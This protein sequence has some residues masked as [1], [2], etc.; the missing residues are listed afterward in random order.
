[1]IN[2]ML[3]R[4]KSATAALESAAPAPLA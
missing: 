3:A 4:I 1:M 2:E